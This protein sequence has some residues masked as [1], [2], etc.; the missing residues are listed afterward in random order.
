MRQIYLAPEQRDPSY[1]QDTL[2]Q[3]R[4]VKLFKDQ[5]RFAEL[6][7][8]PLTQA[9]AAWTYATATQ[10]LH[11]SPEYRV[12]EKAIESAVMLGYDEQAQSYLARYRAVFPQEHA[13]WSQHLKEDPPASEEDD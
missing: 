6:T 12:V 10:L 5:A 8:Q 11:F 1:A 4:T 13:Q 9:N 7:L 2:G 3:L